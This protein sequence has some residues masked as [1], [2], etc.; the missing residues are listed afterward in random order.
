MCRQTSVRYSACNHVIALPPEFCV[1]SSAKNPIHP[2][3]TVEDG[4]ESKCPCCDAVRPNGSEG[5][6]TNNALHKSGSINDDLSMKC[7]DPSQHA[8]ESGSSA[9]FGIENGKYLPVPWV[10]YH[11]SRRSSNS[12]SSASSPSHGCS[13][14]PSS[15]DYRSYSNACQ[16]SLYGQEHQYGSQYHSGSSSMLK[17]GPIRE[18]YQ[19]QDDRMSDAVTPFGNDNHLCK[20]LVSEEQGGDHPGATWTHEDGLQMKCRCFNLRFGK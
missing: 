4:V 9:S 14:F 3:S 15:Y 16:N 12:Q 17:L 10:G 8:P 18:E 13:Q 11:S 5:N 7:D 2:V 20:C 6:P 1:G 19:E